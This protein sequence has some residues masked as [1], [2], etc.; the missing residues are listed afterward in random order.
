MMVKSVLLFCSI[1]DSTLYYHVIILPSI[2]SWP[3][4]RPCTKHWHEKEVPFNDQLS[5]SDNYKLGTNL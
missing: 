1:S 2:P 4:I 5:Q 3:V